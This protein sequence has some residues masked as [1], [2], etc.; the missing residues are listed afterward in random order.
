MRPLKIVIASTSAVKVDACR[1]AFGS[2]VDIVTVKVPS[3]VNEQPMDLETLQGA[4]NRLA[5]ARAAI[6]DA[7]FYVAIE[8][9]LFRLFDEET[10]FVD[11]AIVVLQHQTGL[12]CQTTSD[13][14]IFPDT[15]VEEARR[16]GLDKWTVGR[17]MQEQGIV[18]SHEDPHLTL[19]GR[20]RAEYIYAAVR[21]AC[22]EYVK[23]RV[24]KVV[25]GVGQASGAPSTASGDA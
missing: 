22:D 10:T 5:A 16:R 6:P 7:D 21:R 17:I 19:A 25:L 14:V 11:R 23:A 3:G 20:S 12:Q 18:A 24:D 15:A 13:G 4:N 2:E 8:S 9:G 1:R